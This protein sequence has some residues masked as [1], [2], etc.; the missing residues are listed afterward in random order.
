MNDANQELP[1][2][3]KTFDFITWLTQLT[4]HFPRLHR[5]TIT[6]RLLDRMLDFQEV[7]L[8]AN[9]LRGQSRMELLMKAD[10]HLNK[11]RLYLRLAHRLQWMSMRQYEHGSR[12][13]AE[14]GRLL[15]AWQKQTNTS[16]P[17]TSTRSVGSS[18]KSY[19]T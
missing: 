10:A 14:I 9:S 16:A 1:L 5:P 18:V 8:D 15:G 3:T 13:L 12:L 6:K 11:V 17:K 19:Q 7:L 4:Q 2:F